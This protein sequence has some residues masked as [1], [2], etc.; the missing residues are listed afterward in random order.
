MMEIDNILDALAYDDVESITQYC[1]CEY[2]NKT[3]EFRLINDEFGVID[4]IEFKNGDE[5]SLE[6]SGEIDEDISLILDAIN[7]APYE[8]FHKSDVGAKLN[9]NHESI[10]PQNVPS[11]LR[12]EFY[13]DNDT[14]V[15]IF[16]L[17]KNVVELE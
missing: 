2:N 1:E 9:L 8:V 4:E 7:Q 3:V 17:L 12:T 13:V 11:H 15:I 6:Y 14:G 10:K 16:S 5:W